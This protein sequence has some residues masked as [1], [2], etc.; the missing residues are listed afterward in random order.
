MHVTGQYAYRE[1]CTPTWSGDLVHPI[2]STQ[3]NS[4]VVFF[5]NAKE[6]A[7]SSIS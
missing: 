2:S 1:L 6:M 4:G 5:K 3:L 7:A